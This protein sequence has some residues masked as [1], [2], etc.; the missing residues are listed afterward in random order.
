MNKVKRAYQAEQNKII[1]SVDK[2]AVAFHHF[3]EDYAEENS[4]TEKD[5]KIILNYMLSEY[6]SELYRKMNGLSPRKIRII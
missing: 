1:E 3:A 5:N 6:Q 2:Y 4:L